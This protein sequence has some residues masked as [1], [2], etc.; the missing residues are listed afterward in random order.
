MS[1][2]SAGVLMH[3][4]SLSNKYMIGDLGSCAYE[5]VDFLKAC[6]F[7]WWQV[8]PIGIIGK[9][10]S[11]YHSP[12]AFAGNPLLLSLECLAK[13]NLLSL[14][15]LKDC[16]TKSNSSVNYKKT[17]LVKTKL[18]KKA[19]QKYEKEKTE[20][21]EK[22][23]QKF[24]AH[25]SYWI[26]EFALFSTLQIKLKRLDW[27]LWP[28]AYRDCDAQKLSDFTQK[29][30]SDIRY[31]QFI[32]WKFFEQ[33]NAL[34][35]YCSQQNIRLIGDIPMFV[36]HTSHD[37]WAHKEIF[38]L[39]KN[40][41]PKYEAGVP[42]DSFSKNGQLWRMPVYNWRI[43]K[44]TKYKWW[45]ERLNISM[46]RFDLL[47]FDHFLGFV[48]I[49]EIKAKSTDANNGHYTTVNGKDFFHYLNKK[50]KTF[51]IF[52]DNLGRSVLPA[53]ELRSA[54]K[55][56]GIYVFLDTLKK[57]VHLPQLLKTNYESN[58]VFYTTTHD[59]N[60]LHGWF[61][62]LEPMQQKI[63]LQL[64]NTKKTVLHWSLIEAV[65]KSK[66]KISIIPLQ[67]LL[68]LG[69]AERMN[70]PGTLFHNWEWRLESKLFNKKKENLI[71]AT[72][73]LV[74][75]TERI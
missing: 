22:C 20:E 54:L 65:L 57:I 3:I 14:L 48:R 18:L 7:K 67:D 25:E 29:Y 33:W 51:P 63:I 49:Y 64:F 70:I 69:S 58:S 66:S 45:V 13:Q 73:K 47:R 8:L 4:S 21:D 43:L 60:T 15:D 6:H 23:F 9:H 11:P 39:F 32:Q 46:Q 5:F 26:D 68:G 27:T 74:V 44:N 1:T 71:T 16:E 52:V 10:N 61:E 24:L 36:S 38:K 72:K 59:H 35:K 12:S 62:T 34:K 28:K 2:R 17:K 41:K 37:V 42:P 19:F 55:V 50:F 53:E 75:Q 56:P 30:Q 40:G 31:H